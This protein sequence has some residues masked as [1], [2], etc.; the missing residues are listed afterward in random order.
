MDSPLLTINEVS[1][2]TGRHRSTILNW[3]R[4]GKVKAYKKGYYVFISEDDVKHLYDLKPFL[5]SNEPL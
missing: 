4:K 2:K 1:A 5:P 3:I